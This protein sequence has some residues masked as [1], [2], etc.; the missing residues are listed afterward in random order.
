MILGVLVGIGLSLCTL[1][2][3]VHAISLVLLLLP[4]LGGEPALIAASIAVGMGGTLSILHL[5]YHPVAQS[6]LGHADVAAQLTYTGRGPSVV[7]VHNMAVMQAFY[8][9][10]LFGGIA[11][12]FHL[13]GLSLLVAIGWVFK[14]LGGPAVLVVVGLILKKA[15]RR[16]MTLAVMLAAT[17]VGFVSFHLPALAGSEWGMTAL[18]NGLFTLPAG[19]GLITAGRVT[20][21][22]AQ[23]AAVNPNGLW[24]E[25]QE[26]NGM[27]LGMLTSFLAGVGT[28]SIAG[29]LRPEGKPFKYLAL[30]AA[31]EM[32][33]NIWALLMF[34]LAGTSR[35]GMAAA[36]SE[37]GAGSDAWAGVVILTA[38]GIGIF[39]GIQLLKHLEVPYRQWIW[40]RNQPR[41][42]WL[43]LGSSS[44]MVIWHTGLTGGLVMLC[45]WAVSSLAKS[46]HTPNQALMMALMGPV[47]L[48]GFGAE[49]WLVGRF[50][51]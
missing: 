10:V 37:A 51:L 49:V 28:G 36:A 32:S 18:L 13:A 16:V 15:K 27:L 3:G 4:W 9:V 24:P 41:L 35:S 8:G 50:G 29:A 45:A 33:N 46:G 5:A 30:S 25:G 34:A 38:V 23:E 48:H 6:L 20:P 26:F 2:P 47:L 40:Q 42:G 19:W 12:G 17:A 43:L 14:I 11:V 7:W 22:P 21:L 39:G 1:I 31:A 44:V